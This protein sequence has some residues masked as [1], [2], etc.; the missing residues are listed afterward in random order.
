MMASVFRNGHDLY[1]SE[2]YYALPLEGR[3]VLFLDSSKG[4]FSAPAVGL[5]AGLSGRPARQ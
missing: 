4:E 3:P 1:G 5:A 2:L